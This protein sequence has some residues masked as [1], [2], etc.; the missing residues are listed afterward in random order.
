MSVNASSFLFGVESHIDGYV[1]VCAH[2]M[3]VYVLCIINNTNG[4]V[5]GYSKFMLC[6]YFMK[7]EERFV[8]T[9]HAAWQMQ[10]TTN[11]NKKIMSVP[12]I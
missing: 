10:T 7:Y 9:L 11:F 1:C 6:T 3:R 5:V 4:G 12:I 8:C 2:C